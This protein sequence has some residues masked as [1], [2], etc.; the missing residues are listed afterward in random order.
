MASSY[1]INVLDYGAT[2]NGSTD[3]TTAVQSAIN[4]VPSSGGTVAT[5]FVYG[6]DSAFY[7]GDVSA[8]TAPTQAQ[9]LTRK[10]YADSKVS[11]APVTLTDAATIATNAALGNLFRVTLGG[12]RTLGTPTNPTDGQ[13]AVREPIQDGTG[14][15]T[16][17]LSSAFGLGSTISSVTL[18]T[19]ANKRDFVTAVYNASK[20][21]WYVID[22]V[23]GH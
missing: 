9:H 14:S 6:A 18:T 5:G 16:L 7:E 8:G 15:R 12:N 10:D 17:T 11:P 1:W 2:G 19:T 13:R 23:K 3:D 20:S 21:K 4:A 22:F